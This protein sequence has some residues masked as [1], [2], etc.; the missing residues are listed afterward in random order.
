MDAGDELEERRRTELSVISSIMGPDFVEIPSKAWQNSAASGVQTYELVLRPELDAQKEHVSVVVHIS[1]TKKY[2]NVQPT[3]HVR[4]ND[5]RTRGV[6]P[7]QLNKLEE[8]MNINA[9]SLRGT[10]MIWE[11][12][13]FAQEFIS[14]HNTAPSSSSGAK[15]SLEERMRRRAQAEEEDAKQRTKLEQQKRSDEERQRQN[16]LADRIENET[17]KQMQ[18]IKSEMQRLRDTPLPVRPPAKELL[19]A[20]QLRA[21]DQVVFEVQRVTLESPVIVSGVRVDQVQRGPLLDTLPLG[22]KYLSFPVSTDMIFDT[23]WDLEMVPIS[24]HYYHNVTG[25]RKLEELEADLSRLRKVESDHLSTLICWSFTTLEHIQEYDKISLLCLAHEQNHTMTM[26]DLL[27]QCQT[28]SWARAQ[29]LIRF[30]LQALEDLHRSRLTHRSV[31]LDV[32]LLG[33]ERA[34]LQGAV[35]R[36][37]LLDLHRSNPLNSMEGLQANIP[38]GWRA[39]E[40]LTSPL[41]Y[42]DARDIWDLGRCLSQMLFG[43][44]ILYRTVTPEQFL[45]QYTHS[46]KHGVDP[47]ALSLLHQMLNRSEKGRMSAS[48]LLTYMETTSETQNYPSQ[49]IEEQTT[50]RRQGSMSAIL[51]PRQRLTPSGMPYRAS[52]S[53]V[54]A[55]RVGSFWQLRNTTVPTFQP[56]S[57]YLSDFE[58]VEF[59]GKGAF[60]V[61]VKARNKLDERFYAVKKIRLSS[62]AAEEERTMREIMA[63]SRLDHPHIVRYVTCWIERTAVP[64]LP[65][66]SEISTE[67]A[68]DASPMTTSQQMDASALQA[69]HHMK[70]GNMNDFLSM[71]KDSSSDAEDFIQFGDEDDTEE[72]C[73]E[74]DN[75]SHEMKSA[76]E[77]D[78]HHRRDHPIDSGEV[79][80]DDIPTSSM[81][82]G[83]PD[84]STRVLYIQM[85]YVENQTLGDAIERGLSVDQTWHIFRQMLEALAHIASLGIIHRDLK[86]S[87]VLMDAHGDIKIGDFGL[88]TT[89]LHAMDGGLRESVLSG[90]AA[91]LK[92]LTSGL[93]T[94]SYI[95]PE[96][97]SKQG[98][99]TKYNQKV[100]MFSL[101]IIFFEM[102]ASQRYYTTT[103]ERYQLLR[104]LRMPQ[105][106]FPK[107]WDRTRFS[108]Q[109]QIILQLLDH[110]PA[111]RPTPMAMLRSPLL[112]PKME[113][114]F[115]QE[116]LRLA[117]NPTSVHRH[118]LINALFSRTQTDRIRDFTF[119]T[120]AQ[121]DED[122]VL[123][124][125]VCQHLRQMFQCRGAVPV[126]PPLLFPPSD[127]Y[128]D[129]KNIVKLLDKSGNVV[130]LPFD[131]T[132]PFA[133]ICARSGHTRFKRFDIADVYREN[134]LAG[135]QPR[136]VLAASYDIVSQVCEPAAEA[137]ILGVVDEIVRIPGLAAERWVIEL[138]HETLLQTFLD[139]FPK[140]FHEALLMAMPSILAK[141]TEVRARQQLAQ[142]GFSA[143]MLDDIDAWNIRGDFESSVTQWVSQLT[144][145]ERSRVS[146]TIA[147]LS[148]I[149]RLTH[150]LGVQTHIFFTPLLSHNHT[151][152]RGGTMMAVTRMTSA[153]KQRDVLA[154]GGR[155]DDLLRRFAYPGD[156]SA[157]P[158]HAMGIQ[159]SVGKIVKALAK[160]QQIHLPKLL[161]RPE[162]ERTLG[163]WTP[164]R[165]ECYVASSQPGLLEAKLQLCQLLWAHGISADV[166]YE[167]TAGESPEL[168]VATCRSEG[169]LFLVLVRAHSPVLKVKEVLTRTEHEVNKEELTGVLYDRIARWRRIDQATSSTR[170]FAPTDLGKPSAAPKSVSSISGQT[171]DV[172]V[173]MPQREGRSRRQDRRMKPGTRHALADR[174]SAE[175][176]RMADAL[177][178]SSLPVFA[179]DLVSP[180]L[181]R[182]ACVALVNDGQFRAFLSEENV[183]ADEREYMKQIREQIRQSVHED[184]SVYASSLPSN[185]AELSA[186]T[187]AS[188]A[189]SGSS[190]NAEKPSMALPM[191]RALIYSLRDGRMMLCNEP[192]RG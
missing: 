105:I 166:Q 114:E 138:S 89:N 51:P 116:L 124:G 187:S 161:G 56:V 72:S 134:L 15:L 192:T 40:S 143:S 95:A 32:I 188:L 127:V 83:V 91:D 68:W 27:R 110:D 54:N 148:Q 3:C 4:I 62:S 147:Y 189:L 43:E 152:Y 36:Q 171:Q 9:R 112:P 190:H 158:A 41:H 58:E 99:S 66:G 173:I 50:P 128:G 55:D 119:D 183:S 61:V 101:G 67:P 13:S 113:N 6:P 145:S 46:N 106:E 174:A 182:F 165:C 141:G 181:E 131:L 88:A 104:Q 140:R 65:A 94:F 30:V 155:Y 80:S 24:S 47:A 77:L 19:Q 35:Y 12:V 135:G 107:A 185:N 53:K 186:G 142:A 85:E 31:C 70:L 157:A 38:E 125:V 2:P 25:K 93:G 129:E 57:R 10:E 84:S 111:K 20:E 28:I 153:G 123:V 97:L 8:Q 87:N 60:G 14:T 73:E 118:E 64:S 37:Q 96:V 133:R 100:D 59:L 117:A 184:A 23:V 42:G 130:F 29:P 146:E 160:H 164:R 7:E 45:E 167:E 126:H 170:G 49:E 151:H 17:R 159:L 74:S 63:L 26:R 92:E 154:V 179:V 139:R 168:T 90:S 16:E 75:D 21:M 81:E 169:I 22:R 121:G 115:V 18:A 98:L 11:L 175:A 172:H 44:D 71:D 177:Q 79:S 162:E 102:L 163:P 34:W 109:T 78:G 178:S 149:T 76:A 156:S 69:L 82:H 120:G 103:M 144:S 52:S 122:D 191:A 86:P 108:A 5:T 39:P 1:L 132:V 137:E 33:Q 150:I 48:A 176:K 136:A 180:L